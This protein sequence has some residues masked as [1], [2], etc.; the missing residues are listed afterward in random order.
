MLPEKIGVAAIPTSVFYAQRADGRHLVRWAF[1]KTAP[2]IDAA[3]ER[4]RKL[5][6]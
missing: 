5:A 6:R 4:L 1:C 3:L 2:V